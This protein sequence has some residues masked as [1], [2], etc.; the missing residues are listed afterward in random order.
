ML[1]A[2]AYSSCTSSSFSGSVSSI[3]EYTGFREVADDGPS[4]NIKYGQTL[5]QVRPINVLALTQVTVD[6]VATTELIDEGGR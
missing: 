3:V 2:L 1:S 4:S 6:R 5:S